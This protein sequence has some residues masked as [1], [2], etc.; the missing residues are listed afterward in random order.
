M[1]LLFALCLSLQSVD[2][3]S[4][5]SAATETERQVAIDILQKLEEKSSTNPCVRF[6]V[7]TRVRVS[8]AP[9]NRNRVTTHDI[10][11]CDGLFSCI[12]VDARPGQINLPLH[13]VS[14]SFDGTHVRRLRGSDPSMPK[15]AH[16]VATQFT[17]KG[18]LEDVFL[19]HSGIIGDLIEPGS[20]FTLTRSAAG[21]RMTS[22]RHRRKIARPLSELV[23]DTEHYDTRLL[24]SSDGS[25]DTMRIAIRSRAGQPIPD[26]TLAVRMEIA[27]NCALTRLISYRC[28]TAETAE[29]LSRPES[30]F[31]QQ[32]LARWGSPAEILPLGF[33]FTETQGNE[34][35]HDEETSISNVE[36]L[37]K[38]PDLSATYGWSALRPEKGRQAH[39]DD[40][41]ELLTWDGMA[42]VPD[43][44]ASLISTSREI[45]T[46]NTQSVNWWLLANLAVLPFAL[47]FIVTRLQTRWSR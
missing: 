26:G 7:E 39:F 6:R 44:P 23:R 25:P 15:G 5:D 14:F 46:G 8:K 29:G 33:T 36:E 13:Q 12:M 43:G 17:M 34:L 47:Y 16:I 38:Q 24:P 41:D 42:F 19:K 27:V 4:S 28:E 1:N 22:D 35:I 31:I 32:S 45:P 40:A 2:A 9:L 37:A 30:T 18:S 3:S 21:L 20:L 10:T 11:F